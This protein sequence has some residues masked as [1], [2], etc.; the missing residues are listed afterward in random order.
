M[1]NILIC[2]SI[3]TCCISPIKYTYFKKDYI[4]LFCLILFTFL[5]FGKYL[6]SNYILSYTI[7]FAYLFGFGLLFLRFIYLSLPKCNKCIFKYV[8]TGCI[9]LLLSKFNN[10]SI[11]LE[12]VLCVLIIILFTIVLY[13]MKISNDS[14]IFSFVIC[15]LIIFISIIFIS[16]LYIPIIN[17][18]HFIFLDIK[19][20]LIYLLLNI[21]SNV[22]IFIIIDRML[23]YV[24]DYDYKICD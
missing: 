14:C 9:L 10:L 12:Y 3:W 11:Y 24:Y 23:Y 20:K 8:M 19:I 22:G 13:L 1:E 4:S 18:Y 16:I 7:N 2:L 6:I 17:D 21:Y 5:S 15:G